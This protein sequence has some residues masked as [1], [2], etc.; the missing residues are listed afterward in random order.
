MRGPLD[1]LALW[2]SSLVLQETLSNFLESGETSRGHLSQIETALCTA[3]PASSSLIRA[4]AAKTIFF[5][6]DRAQNINRLL[7]ALPSSSAVSF[8]GSLTENSPFS[9]TV[10]KDVLISIE[11]AKALDA[12]A[13]RKS[14]P[15]SV[16]SAVQVLDRTC[17]TVKSL[18]VLALA[19]AYSLV[20]VL[21]KDATIVGQGL[22][23][24][25]DIILNT[26]G[27]L[28][29]PDNKSQPRAQ[30]MFKTALRALQVQRR[31]S[32][33]SVESGYVSM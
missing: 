25:N 9:S 21:I 5:E 7:E 22:C 18:D 20:L 29:E 19:A 24:L 1:T 10:C 3:P 4:L 8:S 23:S 28:E 30:V 14:D 2:S 17:S 27:E 6:A 26:V 15:A 13:G 11:C 31:S 32:N 16:D 12:L 33:A